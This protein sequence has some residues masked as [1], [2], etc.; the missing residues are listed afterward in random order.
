MKERVILGSVIAAILIGSVCLLRMSDS[1]K[2]FTE[3][4]Y[5]HGPE[6]TGENTSGMAGGI[7]EW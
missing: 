3:N 6:I 5:D 4:L 1:G 2:W 7:T